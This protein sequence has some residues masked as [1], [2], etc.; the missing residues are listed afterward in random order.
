MYINENKS[1]GE[2]SKSSPFQEEETIVREKA[3]DSLVIIAS[4]LPQKVIKDEVIPMIRLSY[5]VSYFQ[6]R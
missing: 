5:V 2:S 6:E 1:P 4:S 3:V